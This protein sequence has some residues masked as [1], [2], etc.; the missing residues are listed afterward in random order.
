MG[1]QIGYAN[2]RRAW[3]DY[4]AKARALAR[5]PGVV[6]VCELGGG[7]NPALPLSFIRQHGLDYSVVDVSAQEL[8]KAPAEYNKVQADVTSADLSLP[9]YDLVL[10]QFLAEHVHEPRRF[11]ANVLSM[12]KPGGRA[13]HFFPTLYGPPFALNSLLPERL[14]ERLLLRLQ[15]FREPEG[16]HGK[17][18]A[19]YRWCRGP[20]RR[21]VQRL[22][23]VGFEVEDYVGYFGHGYFDR[24]RSLGR[25]EQGVTSMLLRWP[26]PALTTYAIVALRRA[27]PEA[28]PS[29]ESPEVS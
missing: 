10:S 7:A 9:S 23:R 6:R 14:T 5:A 11:H 3:D 29:G 16:A 27:V 4:D 20:T 22:E 12:L 13:L 2:W 15:P 25:A 24:V 1:T 19:Y 18:R 8:A 28:G 26:V 21:Q 17:F